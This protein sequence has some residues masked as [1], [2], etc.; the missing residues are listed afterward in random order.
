M[1]RANSHV[2]ITVA[3][4][5]N[6]HGQHG[7]TNNQRSSPCSAGEYK[8]AGIRQGSSHSGRRTFA[9]R[10]YAQTKDMDVVQHLL[11]HDSPDCSMRYIECDKR[12]LRQAFI[13]VI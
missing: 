6:K 8:K 1:R 11:G 3:M 4:V 9:T 7:P 12:I 10:L 13:D 5:L 2:R